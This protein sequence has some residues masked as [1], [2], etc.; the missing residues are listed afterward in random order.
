[1]KLESNSPSETLDIGR[2]LARVLRPGDIVLFDGRLGTGKTLLISGIA[3]GLGVQEQVTSPSFVIVHEYDGFMKIIHADMYR[4]RLGSV[5][6]F[7][8][9]ELPFLARDGVLLIEWGGVVAGALPDHL[10][11]LMTITGEES[12]MVEFAP[13][14]SWTDRSLEELSG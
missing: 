2:R 12:R 13:V 8:D 6:E 3:E 10:R 9:L 7:D 11:V 5:G 1:M 14:G 4:L